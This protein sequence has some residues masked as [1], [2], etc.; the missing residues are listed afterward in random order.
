MQP[1]RAQAAEGSAGGPANIYGSSVTCPDSAAVV[2]CAGA[3]TD[4]VPA[5][6]GRGVAR[7]IMALLL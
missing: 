5:T 7:I 4:R 3:D 2:L 1:H 6:P